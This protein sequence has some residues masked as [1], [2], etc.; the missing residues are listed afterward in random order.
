MLS[1]AFSAL[2]YNLII[3]WMWFSSSLDHIIIDNVRPQLDGSI[4]VICGGGN[5]TISNELIANIL[6][7]TSR[8]FLILPELALNVFG[9]IW[10]FCNLIK[11]T[12][13]EKFTKTVVEGEEEV[14]LISITTYQ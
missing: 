5:N 10:A 13:D 12:A 14:L 7:F 11:C 4:A 3:G 2:A 1:V 6:L 9:T 8:I